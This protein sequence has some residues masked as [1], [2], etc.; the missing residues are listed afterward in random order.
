MPHTKTDYNI[1]D[2]ISGA[3]TVYAKLTGKA[4]VN[5]DLFYGALD[6]L[7]YGGT[8]IPEGAAPKKGGKKLTQAQA[9]KKLTTLLAPAAAE[10]VGTE[11]AGVFDWKTIAALILQ[12]LPYLLPLL[13]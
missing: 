3:K 5:E 4:V 12:I 6:V 1:Q 10:G 2:A 13:G 11:A 7:G 9:K 8:Y